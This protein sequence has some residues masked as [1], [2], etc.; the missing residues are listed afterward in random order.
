MLARTASATIGVRLAPRTRFGI[1]GFAFAA[2]QN[3]ATVQEAASKDIRAI[4][5]HQRQLIAMQLRADGWH[6]VALDGADERSDCVHPLPQLL[7]I[8]VVDEISALGLQQLTDEG[9]GLRPWHLRR[10][11][12]ARNST[13]EG[14]PAT[15]QL[16]QHAE[17]H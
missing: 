12:N 10:R 17:A 5:Q 16:R 7:R 3:P 13:F 11:H 1:A 14:G 2:G 4:Q 9:G 15:M 8:V 6:V